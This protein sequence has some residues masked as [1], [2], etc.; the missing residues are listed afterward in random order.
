[1]ADTDVAH[2]QGVDFSY[3]N[4]DSVIGK[5]ER[6]SSAYT[7]LE[8]ITYANEPAIADSRNHG[9]TKTEVDNPSPQSSR[10]SGSKTAATADGNVY[11][12]TVT[13]NSPAVSAKSQSEDN[14]DTDSLVQ[15]KGGDQLL[16]ES[17]TETGRSSLHSHSVNND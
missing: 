11:Y 6:E 4:Q 1:M 15:L 17:G 14:S 5:D 3:F 9:N 7:H 8:D 16:E 2:F 13:S 12:N 10:S